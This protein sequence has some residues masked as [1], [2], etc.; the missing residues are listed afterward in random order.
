VPGD[1]PKLALVE[2]VR[3]AIVR[4]EYA[5]NQRLIEADL[6]ERFGTTR[7]IARAALQELSARGL[8]EFLPN[9]GARVRNISLDEAIE[10]TE[11]RR[12]LEGHA[13]HRA[14]ERVTDAQAAQL[15]GIIADMEAA[16]QRSELLRYIDLNTQLHTAIRDVSEHQVSARML[17]QLHD[18]MVRH[19]FILALGGNR[20]AVSLPQH[21]AIVMAIVAHDSDGAQRAMHEHLS[22]VIEALEALAV[23]GVP[24]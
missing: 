21:E 5:P 2:V 13:A 19:H 20:P 16:V 7:F 6:C 18:Q 11:I 14:A 8:V 22:S 24:V 17:M 12:L 3:A 4:G 10:I 1:D 23:A 15:R 9:R